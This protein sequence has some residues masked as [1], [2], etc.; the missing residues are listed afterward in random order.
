[1]AFISTDFEPSGLEKLEHSIS[2][3]TWFASMHFTSKSPEGRE[4]SDSGIPMRE[5]IQFSTKQGLIEIIFRSFPFIKT[6]RPEE[7]REVV[8]ASEGA[9]CTWTPTVASIGDA[10]VG[11]LPLGYTRV[12]EGFID[13]YI[14]ESEEKMKWKDTIR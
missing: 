1:M 14:K 11:R 5:V 7:E 4:R 2:F 13:R 3:F 6:V 10:M 9:C 12:Y 8:G